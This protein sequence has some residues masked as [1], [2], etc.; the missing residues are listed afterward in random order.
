MKHSRTLLLIFLTLGSL[1]AKAQPAGYYNGTEGLSGSELKQALHNIIKDHIDFSYSFSRS[2]MEYTDQDPNNP[3]NVILFYLQ[4]SRNADNYGTGGDYINREHVWAKSHGNFSDIRPMDS[5]VHNLHPADASVNEDRSNKDFDNIYPEGY[6]HVEATNC[7]FTD[8]TW[9]PG[10][11]TKGQVART[12][13]YM[14]TRYEGEDSESDLELVNHNNTYPEPLHGNLDALLEWNRKYPPSEFEKRRN[15]RLFRIQQNRN[16]FVDHP[17]FADFIWANTTPTG[18]QFSSLTMSPE[19]PAVGD[20]IT[21]SIAISSS[22]SLGT[23]SCYWG[24]TEN[25]QANQQ[26]MSET[27][28]TYSLQFTPSDVGAGSLLQMSISTTVADST[29][30]YHASYL[31]P[32]KVE[33]SSLTPIPNVQGT[34][35]SSPLN[36][37]AVTIAGRITAN[38]DYTFCMQTGNADYSGIN[39]YNSLFRGQVGDSII[40]SGTVAEYNGVTELTDVTYNYNYKSNSTVSPV[41]LTNQDIA[42]KYEGMLVRIRNVSF[43]NGGSTIDDSGETYTITDNTGQATVY[44]SSSSRLVGQRVPTSRVDL[45]GILSE[46][47]GTY[48]LLPRDKNDIQ[49]ATA[50][51][52]IALAPKAAILYP[53]PMTNYFKIETAEDILEVSISNLNGQKLVE[54][55]NPGSQI[56]TGF[57]TAGIYFVQIE[58]ANH[59]IQQEKLVKVSR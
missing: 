1:S 56:D 39:V 15:E 52:T 38:Y 5:D 45:T 16:P 33:P 36:G 44:I 49:L 37:Q 35:A 43:S 24:S 31:Y 13:F 14:A 4:E 53:N 3:D 46:Y 41:D 28:G 2:I 21:L 17:E 11:L 58:Y 19:I 10:P 23:V 12:L 55:V 50:A 26:V 42:E 20:E 40:V 29:Y 7:Y 18:P 8:S 6:Q 22:E 27:N 25:P 48:Q 57:L 59:T 51:E 47:N 32:D 54:L 34:G 9:E 30:T